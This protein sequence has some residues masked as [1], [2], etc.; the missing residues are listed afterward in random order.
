MLRICRCTGYFITIDNSPYRQI[1]YL[2]TNSDNKNQ[3]PRRNLLKVVKSQTIWLKNVVMCRKYSLTKFAN[4]LIIV[5]R[6][7][8][9]RNCRPLILRPKVL[10]AISVRNTIMRKFANFVRLYFS[11][12]TTFLNQILGFCY[13]LKVVFGNV[14]FLVGICLEQKLVYKENCLLKVTSTPRQELMRV[15]MST[16]QA[17]VFI[18][19]RAAKV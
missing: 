2:W 13:F 5:L 18:P 10:I 15:G 4:F 6:A 14:V 7:G 1:F 19:S 17:R 8:A 16:S 9:G 11:H 12:I 3:I